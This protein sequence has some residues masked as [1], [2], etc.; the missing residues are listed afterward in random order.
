M[1][2]N[3][4]YEDKVWDRDFPAIPKSEL[5]MIMRAIDERLVVDPIGLGKPLRHNL[6]GAWRLR[7]GNRRILY[8]IKDNTV[9]VFA[10]DLRRDAY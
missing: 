3:I 1:P 4:R 6:K 9:T 8:R 7:V 2:Y 5:V 10:I